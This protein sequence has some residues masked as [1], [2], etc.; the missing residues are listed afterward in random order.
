M[1]N[2]SEDRFTKAVIQTLAKRAANRCSNPDC[3]ATTSGP[4]K[5]PDGSVNV[6]EAAHIFG[7]KLGSA[8]YQADMSSV[9]RSDITNAIWLCSNCHKLVDDDEGK[10]PA[11]LLFEW[12]RAH[13][14][15]ISNIIGK[16]GAVARQRYEQRH[17]EEFGRLSYY[18]ERLIVEKGDNWEYKLTAEVLRFEMEPILRRWAALKSGLYVRPIS[19]V[20]KGECFDWVQDRLRESRK[21]AEAFS[22]LMNEE[23]Q[24]AWGEPGVSG[25]DL[26]IVA[27]CRLFA[28]MC[29]S[30]LAWEEIVQFVSVEDIFE[31]VHC[32]LVGI[33]G[34]FIDEASK[35]PEF[36]AST[37]DSEPAF[38]DFQLKLTLEFPQGWEENIFAALQKAHD[39]LIAEIME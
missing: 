4:T 6:G 3:D 20:A 25:S 2:T 28:E 17:L 26:E 23:F 1:S 18:A 9:A 13:E 34:S 27:T 37:M 32:L 39:Q 10:F 12:Q 21:L 7:A 8:R 16:A 14:R 19:R 30:A 11:G 15:K 36:L 29:A 5:K 33:V 22:A 31:P 24:R 35:V 38:G